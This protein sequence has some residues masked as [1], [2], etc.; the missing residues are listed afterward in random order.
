MKFRFSARFALLALSAAG[1][2]GL[3]GCL[4]LSP[5]Y[6]MTVPEAIPER[7]EEGGTTGQPAA[8]AKP[9]TPMIELPPKAQWTAVASGLQE[10][11]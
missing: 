3:A 1:L 6:G 5:D 8:P 4:G 11:I 7:G 2:L 10:P 9:E